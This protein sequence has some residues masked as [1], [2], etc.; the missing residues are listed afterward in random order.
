MGRERIENVRILIA[1]DVEMNRLMLETMLGDLGEVDMVENGAEALA[2][3]EEALAGEDPFNLICLDVQMPVM[4]GLEALHAIRSAEARHGAGR[5]TIFMVTASSDPE[6]MLQ[7][8]ENEGCDDF[9]VKPV[10]KKTLTTLVQKHGL[11]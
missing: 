9:I 7:A 3:A 4:D 5:S 8:L 11:I 6:H 2:A 1:D 10:M